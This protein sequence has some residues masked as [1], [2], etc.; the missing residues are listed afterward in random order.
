MFSNP[1][2]IEAAKPILEALQDNLDTL[3]EKGN[4]STPSDQEALEA[5]A[6]CLNVTGNYP[7][8]RVSKPQEETSVLLWQLVKFHRGSGSLWGYPFFGDRELIDRMD[9]LALLLIGNQSRA[10]QNWKKAL[11]K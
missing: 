10:A 9:T 8:W 1:K 5:I 2:K 4:V 3:R 6:G 7:S 11:G